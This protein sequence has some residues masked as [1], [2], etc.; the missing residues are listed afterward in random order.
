MVP[1]FAVTVG[2]LWLAG[3][4]TVPLEEVAPVVLLLTVVPGALLDTMVP[5]EPLVAVLPLLIAD[6]APEDAPFLTVV[7]PPVLV[8]VVLRVDAVLD[9]V[10]ELLPDTPFTVEPP[11]SEVLPANTLSEPVWYLCPLKGFL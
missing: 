10:P 11:L 9:M 1:L 3:A 7:V 2:L 5:D 4:V 6:P 8:A